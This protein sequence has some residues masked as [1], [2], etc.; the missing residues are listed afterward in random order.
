MKRFA[1]LLFFSVS[2][3]HLGAVA[4][5]FGVVAKATKP[6]LMPT[7]AVYYLLGTGRDRSILILG[8]MLLSLSGDVLLMDHS[9]FIAGLG[10]FLAAHLLYIFGY[11]QHQY[12]EEEDALRGIQRVRLAFPIILAGTGLVVVLYPVLG[13]LRVPVMIYALVMTLMVLNALFRYG[14]TN[15]ASFWL[16][17]TGAI[18]FMASDSVLAI[19]KFLF[20]V[21]RSGLWVMSTYLA[22]QFLIIEGIIRHHPLPGGK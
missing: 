7:L 20:P 1:L 13:D 18:L 22:A 17:L 19:D 11:R 14:K 2:A 15:A 16:V 21:N 4:L 9:F 5:S 8:A 6:L 3:I 10:A 12:A